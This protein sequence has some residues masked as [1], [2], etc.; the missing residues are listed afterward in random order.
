MSCEVVAQHVS[1]LAIIAWRSPLCSSWSSAL[2]CSMACS[3]TRQSCWNLILCSVCPSRRDHRPWPL[4]P[5]G[6]WVSSPQ[7]HRGRA[8]P[9]WSPQGCSFSGSLVIAVR[10][11]PLDV[12][13]KQHPGSL[14]ADRDMHFPLRDR[15]VENLGSNDPGC[16][17]CDMM[18]RLRPCSLW[19]TSFRQQLSEYCVQQSA[20]VCWC[21]AVSPEATDP[22][23]ALDHG[24]QEVAELERTCS[25][26]SQFRG[27]RCRLSDA[28]DVNERRTRSLRSQQLTLQENHYLQVCVS[29]S[30]KVVH[31]LLLL[32]RCF[33]LL[34]GLLRERLHLGNDVRNLFIHGPV[35]D[36]WTCSRVE[37]ARLLL[38]GCRATCTSLRV[39]RTTLHG[40]CRSRLAAANVPV[41]VAVAVDV[42]VAV[43]AQLS[44]FVD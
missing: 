40:S 24:V 12:S 36:F 14:L 7:F 19:V 25:K 21:C 5:N 37:W 32:Q 20:C 41:A 4:P 35:W 28:L 10:M 43:A 23:Q 17:S 11:P 9:S 18:L 44:T 1:A 6:H 27:E 3:C 31:R 16:K 15:T 29:R 38:C 22:C 34:Q 42:P 2:S 30:F 13:K 26:L 39:S 33:L 8:V